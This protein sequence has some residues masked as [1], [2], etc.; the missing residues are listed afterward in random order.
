MLYASGFLF[1]FWLSGATLLH[2]T[3]EEAFPTEQQLWVILGLFIFRVHNWWDNWGKHPSPCFLRKSSNMGVTFGCFQDPVS[4]ALSPQ[5]LP[6]RWGSAKL[7]P[8]AWKS[9]VWAPPDR[10][11]APLIYQESQFWSLWEKFFSWQRRD[12][13]DRLLHVVTLFAGVSPTSAGL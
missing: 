13:C 7:S 8:V 4:L 2:R 5:F 11:H 10:K 1:I 9:G 6:Q 3:R 12:L